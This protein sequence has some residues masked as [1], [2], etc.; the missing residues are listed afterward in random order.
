MKTIGMVVR[1]VIVGRSGV[2]L[3]R[4]KGASWYFL[5]GGNVKLGEGARAALARE[6]REETGTASK[7]G[8][9][10]GAVENKYRDGRG[11]HHELNIVFAATLEAVRICGVEGHLEFEWLNWP[12]LAGIK[13]MPQSLK[14]HSQNGGKAES[15]SGQVR[16]SDEPQISN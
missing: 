12:K 10:I 11:L 8:N 3:C 13:L 14:S 1:A 16:L 5:P 15:F 9:F 4:K 6:I 7:I 2:L